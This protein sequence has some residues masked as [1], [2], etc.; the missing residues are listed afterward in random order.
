[1]AWI[2]RLELP[3]E[4][5]GPASK[6]PDHQHVDVLDPEDAAERLRILNE[7]LGPI[8]SKLEEYSGRWDCRS[9][10]AWRLTDAEH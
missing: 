9:C 3:D 8:G 7:R 5:V 10:R 6:R 1:M 4:R 2:L